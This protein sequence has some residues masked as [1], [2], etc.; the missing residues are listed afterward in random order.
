MGEKIKTD[1]H[2][3]K[4]GK[5]MA[6]R[7]GD[8]L[9]N[10]IEYIKS[11]NINS[12]S[13]NSDSIVNDLNFFNEINFVVQL[14]I[15]KYDMDYSGIYR[16]KNLKSLDIIY[17]DSKFKP[18]IDYSKLN[19]L[20]YLSINWYD[21]EIDLS[22]NKNLKELIIWRFKPKNKSFSYIK[23]PESLERFEI[24]ESNIQ[25]FEGLNLPNLKSFEGHYC[26]KLISLE[27]LK[28]SSDNLQSFILGSCGNLTKYEDLK[29]C[30]NLEKIILTKCGDM[31]SLS[32]LKPLKKVKH[33]TFLYTKV[34][35]GDVSLCSEIKYVAFTN[36]HHYNHKME[37]F[38]NKY[39]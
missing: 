30:K 18:N 21:K 20:E 23:L 6:I 17:R 7:G 39:S 12:L 27:G 25:N 22:E 24:T 31:Q 15:S 9:I 37:E 14:Y 28:K 13:I 10:E 11:K 34:L 36:S 4:D 1:F 35:D 33:F 2:F 26:N 32:W 8:N 5:T 3:S 19:K 38:N 29:Y 16:L